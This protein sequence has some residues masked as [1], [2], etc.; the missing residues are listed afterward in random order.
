MVGGRER[1][2]KRNG[3]FICNI[4]CESWKEIGIKLFDILTIIS[5]DDHVAQNIFEQNNMHKNESIKEEIF[6]PLF[7]QWKNIP[8][9]TSP[10]ALLF[11]FFHWKSPSRG[12]YR[13]GSDVPL[14][15][16]S[17]HEDLQGPQTFKGI[18]CSNSRSYFVI[19]AEHYR[20]FRWFVK[21]PVKK[22][23]SRV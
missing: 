19:Q 7:A 5:F 3:N 17:A 4:L 15:V 20:L 12:T 1:N 22:T 18:S 9:A 10:I 8:F 6:N 2:S 21:S 23:K 13:C 11:F 14:K 16:Q